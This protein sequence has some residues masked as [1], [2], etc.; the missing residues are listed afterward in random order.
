[1]AAMTTTCRLTSAPGVV[2]VKRASCSV[3]N[4]QQRLGAGQGGTQAYAE[5]AAGV[6]S[7][8]PRPV[9][10]RPAAPAVGM[11][12]ILNM[13]VFLLTDLDPGVTYLGTVR[14]SGWPDVWLAAAC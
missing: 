2:P 3:G 5:G 4:A 9:P 12:I 8:S 11:G 14:E 6:G 10:G 7:G 1:V 13:K